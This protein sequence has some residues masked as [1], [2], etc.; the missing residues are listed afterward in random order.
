MHVVLRLSWFRQLVKFALVG[1]SSFM[2]DLSLYL[3]LTRFIFWFSQHYII[4]NTISFLLTVLWS[5]TLNRLWTFRVSSGFSGKQYSKFLIV[6]SI[7]L[8][9]SSGLLYLAVDRLGLY[10]VV[11]KFMVAVVVMTWNFS[12]NKFWTFRSQKNYEA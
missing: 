12:A 2:I 7:G 3:F 5:F 6:S 4:A 10:D 11:A 9:L 8:S 1:V